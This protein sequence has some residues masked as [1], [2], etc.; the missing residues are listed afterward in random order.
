M[1][2]QTITTPDTAG[3]LFLALGLFFGLMLLFVLSLVIRARNLRNDEAVIEQLR[4]D[5]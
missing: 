1:L 4:S 2:A 5:K 3:Y